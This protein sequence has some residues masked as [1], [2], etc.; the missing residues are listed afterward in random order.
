MKELFK[1]LQV[2]VVAKFY[3]VIVKFNIYKVLALLELKLVSN[4][5]S[6]LD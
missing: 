4:R 6:F 3:S 1:I 5:N 2:L